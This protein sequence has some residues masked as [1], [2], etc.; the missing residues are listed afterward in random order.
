[1]V[2]CELC[3][4]LQH[5]ICFGLVTELDVPSIHC[6]VVCSKVRQSRA[7]VKYSTVN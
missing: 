5:C 3:N 2:Q 1:M 7:L 4:T 6:C